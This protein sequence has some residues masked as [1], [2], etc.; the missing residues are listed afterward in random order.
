MT[1]LKS[2]LE[3]IRE[4][5]SEIYYGETNKLSDN[6]LWKFCRSPQVKEIFNDFS[7][8]ILHAILSAGYVKLSDVELDEE[9]I[10][11]IVI[12]IAK[13]EYIQ[14]K[15]TIHLIFDSRMTKDLAHT[16]ATAK[17]VKEKE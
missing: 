8:T 17:I 11:A 9:K 2:E 6:E 13:K 14:D 15:K 4:K 10:K 7:Q 16:I 1:T 5:Y 3:G 12:D